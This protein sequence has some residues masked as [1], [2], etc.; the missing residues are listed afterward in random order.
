MLGAF[1]AACC[2]VA[3]LSPIA[4]SCVSLLAAVAVRRRTRAAALLCV[5]LAGRVLLP[6]P[7]WPTLPPARDLLAEPLLR[8]LPEPDAGIAAG[9]LLGGH[10]SLPRELADAFRRTGTSHLLAASGFNITLAAGALGFALRPAGVRLAAAG[11]VA[12]AVGFALVAGFSPSIARAALMSIVATAGVLLGRPSVAFNALGAAVLGLLLATPGA[13]SDVGFLL[14]VTATAGLV[15]LSRPLETRLL[16]PPWLRSQLAGTL[17][18]SLA[19]L[20]VAAEAFG[21]ASVISPLANLAVA[22][23][24]APLMGAAGITIALGAVAPALAS[25]PAWAAFICARSLRGVVEL[26][27]SLPFA[28]VSFPHAGLTILALY[29]AGVV[30]WRGLPRVPRLLAAVRRRALLA[31]LLAA[32]LV[33]A[34]VTYV[35]RSPA[36][37]RIVALDV[38]QGDAFLIESGGARAL[39]DGGPDPNRTLKAL[40][41]ALPFMARR[42]DVLALTHSH[43]DHGSGLVAVVARYEIGL[44]LEPEGVEP[45]V[46]A[47]AWHE[48]LAARGVPLRAV[49]RGD[50]VRV[51]DL[52]IDV[53][54]PQGD[55]A[56]PLPNLALR[57]RAGTL[58]ALFLGDASERGQEDLLL[59][60][61]DLAADVYVP[62]HHG[63]A[64]PHADA[65]VAAARPRLALLSVGAGN[66]YGHPTP[67][68]LRA[69]ANVPTLRTDRDGTLEVFPDGHSIACRK[70][71]AA[72]PGPWGGWAPRAPPC[73]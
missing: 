18:A 16:G 56:D 59:H 24:V 67:Q 9:A 25:V 1:A 66:R 13:V 50:R 47:A 48:A 65:L 35:V 2:A 64:T 63:A 34:G 14:S 26:G 8:L 62:P 40:G 72:L 39:V 4:A 3:L 19:S 29:G 30:A 23:L 49:H 6:D 46:V 15:L 68:T 21:R 52:L 44:A 17:A 61:E 42:I 55:P 38:G 53:L 58:S 69:L 20:P 71:A 45:N 37:P 41:E 43:A 54:A 31:V 70:R 73:G 27:A 60:A 22:P 5:A 12:A 32:G 10:G 28:S 11:T 51:G 57:I 7:P 33:A 36:V